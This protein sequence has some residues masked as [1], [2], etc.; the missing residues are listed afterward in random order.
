M[1]QI[2]IKRPNPINVVYRL[3][4]QSVRHVGIF[5]SSTVSPPPLFFPVW[6]STGVHVFTQCVTRG[7]GIGGLRQINTCHQV[8]LLVNF[9]VKQTFSV[10]CLYKYLVHGY[11]CQVRGT[12]SPDVTG[13]CATA[14]IKTSA[15]SSTTW[16]MSPAPSP[17]PLPSRA[18]SNCCSAQF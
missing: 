3:E 1:D 2:S 18:F 12:G 5:G 14:T 13:R 6:I 7:G 4:I 17:I 8:P 11:V 16:T 9:E 10:R 15:T